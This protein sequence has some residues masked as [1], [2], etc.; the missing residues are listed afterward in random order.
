MQFSKKAAMF[1]LDARVALA[2]FGA[3]SVI[4]GA[5][6]YNAIQDAKV[7]A[8]MTE[9][10]NIDKA[11]TEYYIDTGTY[12]PLKPTSVN[13]RLLMEELIFSSVQGWKGPY[14]TLS[15]TGTTIDGQLG[16]SQYASVLIY[17][18]QDIDWSD[19]NAGSKCLSGSASCSVYICYYNG[20]PEDINKALDLKI[21][22]I[23]SANQGNFRY[24][25][26]V[27]CK[28]GMTYNKS[29]APES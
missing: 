20:V 15:D 1:G 23:A 9:L 28:K 10:D 7:V 14:V 27:S 13:G 2:I 21:D 29:L 25:W 12:P 16:H 17:R 5:A 6:L 8:L 18:Q 26:W 3:L 4:T 11:I 19:P 22:G 24:E